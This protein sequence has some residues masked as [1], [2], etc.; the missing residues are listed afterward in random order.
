MQR[1]AIL[2]LL[3]AGLLATSMGGC[4]IGSNERESFTG[5]EV[6]AATFNRIEPGVTTADWVQGTL[7]EPTSKSTLADGTEILKW[8]YS[9][10][11]AST[12]TVLFI[13]GG[14]S[15][16]TTAGSAY[17]EIK[18]GIVTRAWRTDD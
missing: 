10:T 14:S 2:G 13:F 8:S 17:V 18:N 3:A 4:L 15:S 1:S 5:K 16:K 11:K 12:G 7:G 6:S 9:K